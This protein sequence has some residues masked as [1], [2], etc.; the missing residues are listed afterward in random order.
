VSN[1]NLNTVSEYNATTG[2]TISSAFINGQGL[3][4][5]FGL[6]LDGNNHLFVGN[7]GAGTVGEYNAATGATINSTFVTENQ[8]LSEADVLALDRP[9]NR[10]YVADRVNN[11]IAQFD[12]TT[13][14]TTKFHFLHV[15]TPD[16]A[17]DGLNHLFVSGDDT[18]VSEY[19]ATTGAAIN[20]SNFITGLHYAVGI[21]LDGNNDLFVTN[22]VDN[23]VGKYNATT[24]A[25]INPS[26]IQG[27]NEP[28]FIVFNSSVPEPSTFALAAVGFLGVFALA[29]QR[30]RRS[31]HSRQD[32]LVSWSVFFGDGVF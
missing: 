17:L 19:D 30:S 22:D 25:A 5:P 8:G 6:A 10:L 24:G 14:A 4:T 11:N 20:N 9:N 31:D 26:I 3:S 2:A 7:A 18:M 29:R 21:A 32:R 15:D 16:M 23:T 28:G 13:G 12:A 1:G 27:L